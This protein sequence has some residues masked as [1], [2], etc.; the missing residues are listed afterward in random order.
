MSKSILFVVALVFTMLILNGCITEKAGSDAKFKHVV[1]LGFDGMSSDG[2][3]KA[4]TPNFDKL[5]KEGSSSMH[6]RSV[7]PSKSSPNWG[8]M[9]MGA[10]PE[11]TGI[12]SN[13]WRKDKF[14]LPAV[15]KDEQDWFPTIFRLIKD[16]K[17]NSEVGTIYHWSG[18]QEL[19]HHADVDH[20]EDTKDEFETTTAVVKYIKE[21]KPDFLFVQFDQIDIAGHKYGFMAD[22][23][24]Q[25]IADSDQLLAE[26]IHAIEEAGIE[27]ETLVIVNSDHGG[28]QK[29][30]G[31]ET[32]EEIE[33]PVILWGKG[34]KKG[35]TIQLPV[36]MYDYAAIVADALGLKQPYAWIGRPVKTA[37]EGVEVED[38][39]LLKNSK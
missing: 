18:F 27:N 29:D 39:Y 17:S 32:M 8:A 5:M 6:V 33:T 4:N 11:Q 35:Y 36:Y 1:L 24:Y 21:K 2:L 14:I 31:G 25:S 10:G 20:N 28:I 38:K 23:Y 16:Q 19:F 12:T 3:M 7:L 30:H 9:L 34:I 13:E 26:V 37:Y 22:E 15:V